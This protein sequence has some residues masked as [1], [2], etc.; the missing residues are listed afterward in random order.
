M[1]KIPAAQFKAKCLSVM[2]QVSETGEP[3]LVT[4]HGKPVVRVVPAGTG[5]EDIFG[6]MSGKARIAGD[7]ETTTPLSDWQLS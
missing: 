3:V 4:K 5:D 6:F 2:E 7:V 1:Q